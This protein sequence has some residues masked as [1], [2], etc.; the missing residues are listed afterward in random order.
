MAPFGAVLLAILAAWCS[1]GTIGFSPTSGRIGVLPVSAEAVLLA[2]GA[3]AAVAALRRGGASLAPI[4]LLAFVL[5][6]WLPV[7]VP[8]AFLLWVQ[9]L[10]LVVWVGVAILMIAS[11]RGVAAPGAVVA[12]HP[13]VVAASLAILLSGAAAWRVAPMIPGGDEPRSERAM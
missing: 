10:A 13:R 7:P 8:A 9:P 4:P 11:L 6:P 5:L 3:G 1:Q 2:L 12:R